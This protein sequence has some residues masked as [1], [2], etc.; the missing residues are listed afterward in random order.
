M[1]CQIAD[2]PGYRVTAGS[3]FRRRTGHHAHRGQG[4]IHTHGRRSR[5]IS[6]C[7]ET[8]EARAT[9]SRIA[10]VGDLLA[11]SH[12][13]NSGLEYSA[14]HRSMLKQIFYLEQ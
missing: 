11:I 4:T 14:R 1:F 2:M 7:V 5:I 8:S 13:S 10:H 9:L 12:Q 6:D 3:L